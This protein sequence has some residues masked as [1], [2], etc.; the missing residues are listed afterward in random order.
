MKFLPLLLALAA[1]T[2]FGEPTLREQLD[3][4]AAQS[5]KKGDPEVRAMYAAGIDTV[6]ASGIY[7]SV[8]KVGDTA[9]MFALPDADGKLVSLATLLKDG[10]V[11]VTWYR[12]GWCPYCNIALQAMQEKLPEIHKLGA[13]LVALT[14]EL[15]DYSADTAT[16]NSLTFEVLSDVGNKV[17]RDYG[18]VFK[19]TDGVSASMRERF[20]TDTRN[21]DASNELPLSATF[22]IDQSGKITYLF[23]DANYRARAEP[24]RIIDALKAL[25]DGPTPEHMLLQFWENTWNP[26][27]D[28]GLIDQLMTEDFVIT[29]GGKDIVGRPAF[30][31]WVEG[32]QTKIGSLH[33]EN[34]ETFTS[35]AGDRVVSRL[36]ATGKNNGL[37][38]TEPDGSPVSFTVS[39]IWEVR[40]G[41]LA[42]NWVER[43]AYE[44][45][46][47]LKSN[48]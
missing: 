2:A 33:V 34:L 3:A 25:K 45:W 13:Q 26:P 37:F 7:E 28:L 40:D 47:S 14:P 29:T 43:S 46:Q 27:Y 48:E 9:P 35:A 4:R 8:K 6:A 42:H 18:A 23:A 44:L 39:A 16:K 31:E 24:S 17:A 10:P 20:S 38:D 19:M 30:K 22:V 15:P 1:T 11:V 21:G 41:K 32:F 12:G 36:L 5:A